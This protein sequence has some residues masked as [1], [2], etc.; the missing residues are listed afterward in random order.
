MIGLEIHQRLDTR[1]LHCNC[2]AN[3]SEEKSDFHVDSVLHRRL[4]A[5]GG[6]LG[7]VDVAAAYEAS[8]KRVFEYLVDSRYSCLVESDE[9]PPCALNENALI[10]VLGIAKALNAHVVNEAHVM[11]KTITDGSSVSGFQR[12]T[13]VATGGHLETS[14]GRVEMQTIAVEEESAGIVEKTRDKFVFRLDRLGIPLV[15]IATA[16]DIKDG[17]HAKEVAEKLGGILRDSG[18]VQRGLGSI[19]QDLN[20]SVGG[21][22]RVELKG[23]QDLRL[24]PKIIDAEIERQKRDGVRKGGE[25]RR[26]DGEGSEFMRPLPGAARIYPETDCPHVRITRELLA[27]AVVGESSGDK[28]A[29]LEKLGLN[30]QLAE[31]IASAR[32]FDFFEKIREKTKADPTTV[33]ST[34]L[35]TLTSLRREG[36]DVEKISVGQFE[37]AFKLFA[38]GEIAKTALPEVIRGLPSG[39]SAAEIVSEKKLR[40]FTSKE[41]DE[42]VKSGK[43]FGEIMR[44]HRLR[45][46][47]A[48]LQKKLK[49]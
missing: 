2:Y 3:P 29:R 21:G 18:L 36:V 46:D 30:S 11:R 49:R 35:E 10:A 38:D 8:K 37:E 33:A 15:E 27:K 12:T 17:E 4:K 39:K 40:K 22:E 43:P 24:L 23:V 42:L 5:V 45:V 16:P 13:L 41:L 31:R 14:K 9:N 32:E 20:I 47:A 6:E 1:K 26:I 19:R 7:E 34:L 28:K 25:T 48:E 44:E